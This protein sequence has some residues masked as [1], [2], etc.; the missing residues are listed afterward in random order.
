[1]FGPRVRF[2]AARNCFVVDSTALAKPMPK[3]NPSRAA[4]MRDLA[5]RWLSEIAVWPETVQKTQAGILELLPTGGADLDNVARIVG[6]SRP[7]LC[8]GG[9]SRRE[10]PSTSC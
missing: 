10:R 7:R 9:C 1:M 5:K 2:N 8:D 3:S 6:G 4:I